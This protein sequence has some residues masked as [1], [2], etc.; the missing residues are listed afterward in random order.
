MAVQNLVS[1]SIASE[2]KDEIL[3]AIADIRKKLGFLLNLQGSEV[4]GLFKAGKEFTP[5]L[6]GCH[7]VAKA[8]PEILPGVFNRAE[9][10]QDYQLS[11]DLASISEALDQLAE[12]VSHTLTAA[13]S[14]ALVTALDVYAA[15]KLNR[16]KVAG[17][18][19]VADN[20]GQYFKR[21]ARPTGALAR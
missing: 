6:D 14:D 20:L 15:V 12:G 1:A 19:S 16:D 3:K 11:Q 10:D 17:L 7:T 21:T 9:F 4:T 13:R 5:F 2:T 18:G 8:H